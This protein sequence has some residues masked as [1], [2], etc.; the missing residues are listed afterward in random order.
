MFLEWWNTTKSLSNIWQHV[1]CLLDKETAKICK[2][3]NSHEAFLFIL[4]SFILTKKMA[5]VL[6]SVILSKKRIWRFR[7]EKIRLKLVCI[8]KIQVTSKSKQYNVKTMKA[9]HRKKSGQV[10]LR[11]SAV[12]Q[13]CATMM[14]W[15]GRWIE[16]V[17][18]YQIQNLLSYLQKIAKSFS[19]FLLFPLF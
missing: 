5:D 1:S 10:I 18:Y 11:A 3:F 2:K 7:H 17:V 13:L 16:L 12:W 8:A 14:S 4:N 6:N 19:K 9:E 15:V